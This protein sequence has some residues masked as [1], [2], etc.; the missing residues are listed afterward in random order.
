MRVSGATAPKSAIQVDIGNHPPI[1][2]AV[3]VGQALAKISRIIYED[4]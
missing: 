3:T 2:I 4:I 1:F